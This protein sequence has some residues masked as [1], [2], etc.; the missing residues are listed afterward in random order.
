MELL[1]E[2]DRL[3]SHQQTQPSIDDID[4]LTATS[5]TAAQILSK[6]LILLDGGLGTT[7]QDQ[8]DV[9]FSSTTTP[10]WSS[11]LLI[12]EP[13]TLLAAQTAFSRAGAEILLSATYQASFEGYAATARQPQGPGDHSS[14]SALPEQGEGYTST[15]AS[16]FMRSAL[17]ISRFAIGSRPGV[18]AL[19]LGPYGATML[20]QSTEY[21]GSYGEMGNEQRLF[22]W[23][24]RRIRPYGELWNE[25]DLVAWETVPRLNEVRA[26]RR[27]MKRIPARKK[28][29]LSCVF[30]PA[31]TGASGPVE[32][33]QVGSLEASLPDGSGIRDV[34]SAM[35]EGDEPTPWAIGLNCT[36]INLVSRLV[37][38]FEQSAS[39]LSL[40]LPRLV[41]YPD[42]AGGK[43]YDAASETWIDSHNLQANG[44]SNGNTIG[45]GE[46]KVWEDQLT[47]IVAEVKDRGR[48][49]GI[50]VGGCC[51]TTPKMVGKL[52][53]KL[54]EH[55]L[56]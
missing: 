19:S 43:R 2:R 34:L 48:W 27:V 5:D 54:F 40:E 31:S 17:R 16:E 3:L 21:S 41:I 25:F 7:L 55:K 23:H 29:W 11:H 14:S 26:I 35:L 32:N 51:K 39:E 50:V 53:K 49:K 24:L 18:I 45:V 6:P 28:Y 52:K 12:D 20:P 37:K 30:V 9:E 46:V 13:E 10:T 4:R 38:A 33:G 47:E 15:E 8:Y 22:D 1:L 44:S 36:N 56:L 42:G